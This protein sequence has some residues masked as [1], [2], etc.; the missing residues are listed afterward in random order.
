MRPRI[1][2]IPGAPGGADTRP[3]VPR[4]P[5]GLD[6]AVR[7]ALLKG[8]GITPKSAAPADESIKLE[9]CHLRSSEGSWAHL[10][11]VN[12]VIEK[13]VM[14]LGPSGT[15]SV[16]AGLHLPAAGSYLLD[17]AVCVLAGDP[18]RTFELSLQGTS[19]SVSFDREGW[20]HLASIL[21][22]DG[23]TPSVDLH[24]RCA[25]TGYWA[26]GWLELTPLS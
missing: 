24:L 23:V 11:N 7:S 9:L 18:K 20:Q 19:Q 14:F 21:K 10:V 1:P 16:E 5:T 4:P 13:T 25:S 26:F 17:V 2:S 3:P 6:E 8:A 22:T 12:A 15:N